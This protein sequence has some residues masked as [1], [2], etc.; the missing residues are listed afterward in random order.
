MQMDKTISEARCVYLVQSIG[1]F[2][3]HS[4][5]GAFV[6]SQFRM[7]YGGHPKFALLDFTLSCSTYQ[8]DQVEIVNT[9]QSCF[10]PQLAIKIADCNNKNRKR[11]GCKRTTFGEGH[12]HL[13]LPRLGSNSLIPAA[14]LQFMNFQLMLTETRVYVDI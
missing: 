7:S 9:L 6:W 13:R 3:A 8:V 4:N 10:S 5:R 11:E 12:K 2:S 14:F 1:H